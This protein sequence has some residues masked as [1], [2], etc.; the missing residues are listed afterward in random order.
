MAKLVFAAGWAAAIMAFAWQARRIGARALLGVLS[1]GLSWEELGQARALPAATQWLLFLVHAGG[2]GFL[3]RLSGR[4]YAVAIP[5]GLATAALLL[6]PQWPAL[7]PWRPPDVTPLTALALPYVAAGLVAARLAPVAAGRE[8]LGSAELG[9]AGYILLAQVERFHGK[10]TLG[11]LPLGAAPLLAATAGWALVAYLGARTRGVAGSDP[12]CYA[13]VAVDL[14]RTGDPRHLF[15]LFP[16]VKDLHIAWWPLVHVGYYPPAGPL[17]LAPSVWPIG[18]PAILSLFYRLLGEQ[19]LYLGAPVAGLL[20]LLATAALLWQVWPRERARERGLALAVALLVLATSKEQLLWLLVPMADVPAQ[21]CTVLAVWLALGAAQL[22]A[23]SIRRG[24]H[25]RMEGAIA[26]GLALGVAYDI[27]HTQVLLAPVLLLALWPARGRKRWALV[28]AAGAGAA[29]AAAPDLLYHRW[30]FDSFWRPESPEL[31]LIGLRYWWG[32]AGRMAA[33]FAAQPEFGLLLPFLGYGLWRA[34]RE[35]W[36]GGAVLASWALLSAGTQFLYGPLR[37]RDLLTVLP[38]LAIFTA[39]GL[40]RSLAGLRA[41]PQL[42]GWVALA[43]AGLLALRTVPILAWPF[44]AGEVIFGYLNPQ[45]RQAF[46]LLGRAVERGAVI[47]TSLNSGAVELYTGRATCRP[48]AW[49]AA[50]LDQFLEAMAQ[51][52]RPVYLLDDGNEQAAALA[53]LRGEGRL[54]PVRAFGVP[55]DRGPEP[56]TGALYRVLQRHRAWAHHRQRHRRC[57]WRPQAAQETGGFGQAPGL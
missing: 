8:I 31:N 55:V 57:A 6:L 26:A 44:Q 32:N 40:A 23:G 9:A 46:D 10:R 56:L 54:E 42:A 37:W 11:R 25:A 38:A 28:L 16:L 15:M 52:G 1:R 5:L 21:L 53:R 19:G 41:R 30:A 3:W 22:A 29:L 17:G 34:W 20:S 33:A 13:Q 4:G 39:Y 7:W 43:C 18:W 45:Q 48:G 12:Y 14:A 49:S 51:A 27:R 36:H 2:L 47:G 50:E 24:H 35:R